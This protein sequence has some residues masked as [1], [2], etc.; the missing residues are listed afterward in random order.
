MIALD[1][2]DGP[3]ELDGD[4]C[5]PCGVSP[6]KRRADVRECGTRGWQEARPPQPGDPRSRGPADGTTWPG[7]WRTDFAGGA[8][9]KLDTARDLPRL[10]ART[11][12]AN[13]PRARCS[14]PPVVLHGRGR[15]VLG[16]S[17]PHRPADE[18]AAEGLP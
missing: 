8:A 3:K 18:R 11:R 13:S 4:S 6:T 17:R 5:P 12:G 9:W 2:G 10:H 14:Q 16:A 7:A 15:F 1:G